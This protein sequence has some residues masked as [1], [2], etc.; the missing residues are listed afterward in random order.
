[1]ERKRDV[2]REAEKGIERRREEERVSERQIETDKS[3]K[4]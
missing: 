2:D 4:R 3:L 1:M